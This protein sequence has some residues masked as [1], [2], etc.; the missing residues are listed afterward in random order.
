MTICPF[1]EN[2]FPAVQTSYGR[3]ELHP[4]S[5][6]RNPVVLKT[7]GGTQVAEP[8]PGA[9]D[10]R[11]DSPPQSVGGAVLSVLHKSRYELPMLRQV[12]EGL[13]R[14]IPAN[15]DVMTVIETDPIVAGRVIELANGEMFGGLDRAVDLREAFDR[16]GADRI[17]TELSALANGPVFPGRAPL[18]SEALERT[19]NNS[20]FA[21]HAAREIGRAN[22]VVNP[23]A[24]YLAGLLHNAGRFLLYDVIESGSGEAVVAVRESK[25]LFSET[26][27]RFH[28]LA[29][30]HLSERWRLPI[31][32]GIAAFA[33]E[34]PA[35]IPDEAFAYTTQVVALADSIARATGYG[36]PADAAISL[37]AHP[38]NRVVRVSDVRIA[39]MRIDLT[40]RLRALLPQFGVE[41]V[42]PVA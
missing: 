22:A 1:C 18:V 36:Y 29:A 27:Q 2:P 9:R 16:L 39:A 34:E 10:I 38:A 41:A 23:D 24:L 7:V 20:V 6:C 17:R 26:I 42:R 33:Y 12:A 8:M 30:L 5:K 19:W 3:S 25:R 14:S 15:D 4:C 11:E 28:P 21:A 32:I 35:R 37:L 31:D 13:K 40:D